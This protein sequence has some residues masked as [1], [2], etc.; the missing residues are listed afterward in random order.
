MGHVPLLSIE[1][2]WFDP[3]IL[4]QQN[5]TFVMFQYALLSVIGPTNPAQVIVG[6][7]LSHYPLYVGIEHLPSMC[8]LGLFYP[9]TANLD[10]DQV[11]ICSSVWHWSR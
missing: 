2:Q 11:L 5:G 10:F 4:L 3:A 7:S 6:Y 8:W 1:G 9:F